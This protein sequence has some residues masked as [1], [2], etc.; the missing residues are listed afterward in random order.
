[1]KYY[2]T[3]IFLF[4]SIISF[5]QS[6][7]IG[8]PEL[9]YIP[10]NPDYININTRLQFN[11]TENLIAFL[12]LN[13]LN[14]LLSD[15]KLELESIKKSPIGTH[16][17]FKHLVKGMAVYQSS[18]QAN[19]DQSG[20]L[21]LIINNL[22][23]YEDY[24]NPK[25]LVIKGDFWMNTNY[26]L[27]PAY[28]TTKNDSITHQSFEYFYT[29]EGQKLL[30]YNPKLYYQSPDSMVSAMV[31]LPN[32]IVAANAKYG[33]KGFVD[34]WDK[35]TTEL[36]NAR[37]KVRVPLKFANGKFKLTNGLITIKNIHDPAIAPIEPT[38][39]F[40]NYTRDQSGFEDINAFYH[41]HNYST[42]LRKIGF[43]KLLDSIY[44]DTH[45]SS[46]D[47]NSSFDPGVYPYVL[48]FGTGNVDD[49]E[50]GQVVIHEFGHSL[51]TLASQGTVQG[52]QRIAM[53]EGQADY[54]AMSYSLSLNKNKRNE[55]FSWDGHNEF[56]SGFTTN[57][58]LKYKDLTGI[59][60]VDREVWSTALM[61]IRDKF[62]GTKSDSIIFSSYYLQA[63]QST[64][65]QMAR[66]ILKMDSILFKGKDVAFIWQCFTDRG[67][68]DTVPRSLTKLNP[69]NIKEEIKIL[70]TT[71][72]SQ[73]LAP[74]RI[75]LA[76][77]YLW[78]AIEIYDNIG[79][80]IISIA[81]TKEIIL[82]PQDYKAGVYYLKFNSV[83]GS[84]NISKKIIRF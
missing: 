61:C 71:D 75:Q 69:I 57:T 55:V 30:T 22:A 41:L 74:L 6:K 59:K 48:E 56:W 5:S 37:S 21:I 77:P 15:Q 20:N 66:V 52:N 17:I 24:F 26:G 46:G 16:Y 7:H 65:P 2:T 68:L 58:S 8:K 62:R 84:Q 10:S 31:Y 45:G 44:V 50:D 9:F 18:I 43:S 70:N 4:L 40:L 35:N 67:I 82:M 64:M 27:T 49:A 25:S 39:T 80:K 11:S 42:Y 79:Q 13:Y 51:S 29:L 1:M 3:T 83:S 63:S 53:E 54:V 36:T 12:E 38:D 72:Y 32:P 81:T 34:D 23:K 19:Y 73:G 47:D 33:D 28:K 76:N 60:D 14:K 78:N